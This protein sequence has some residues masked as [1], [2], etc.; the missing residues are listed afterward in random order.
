MTVDATIYIQR[1]NGLLMQSDTW[2]LIVQC[3][4]ALCMGAVEVNVPMPI[5]MLGW[6]HEGGK[7]SIYHQYTAT[8]RGTWE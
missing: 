4:W 5:L 2:T 7:I 6:Q 3:S 1:T 8:K